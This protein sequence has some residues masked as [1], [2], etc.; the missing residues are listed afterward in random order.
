MKEMKT[1]YVIK[2][3]PNGSQC[4]SANTGMIETLEK[5]SNVIELNSYME[6]YLNN[7]DDNN[8]HFVDDYNRYKNNMNYSNTL[9]LKHCPVSYENNL[10]KLCSMIHIAAH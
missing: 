9:Y 6:E 5:D 10:D 3:L 4:L 8:N 1:K 2:I 7:S